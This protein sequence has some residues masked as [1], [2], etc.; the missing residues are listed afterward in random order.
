MIF[1]QY[2]LFVF[3][4]AGYI[5]YIAETYLEKTPEVHKSGE[6]LQ[7]LTTKALTEW[8]PLPTGKLLFN[9][10]INSDYRI[11]LTIKYPILV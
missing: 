7:K 10:T 11:V 6:A 8:K 5:T 4:C 3:I 2:V 9:V 1:V